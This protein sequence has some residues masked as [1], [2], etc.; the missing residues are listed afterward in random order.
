MRLSA[1]GIF[2]LA[3]ILVVAAAGLVSLFWTPLNP[4]GINLGA[5]LQ[6]PS[7]QNLFGTD[8]FGRD[9]FSRAMVGARTSLLISLMSVGFAVVLGTFVGIAAGYSRGFVDRI[10]MLGT[11]ALLAFPGVLLALGIII[12]FG[13]SIPGLV[14]ALGLSYAPSV[15]RVVRSTVLSLRQRE[16]IEAS[17]VI[18]NSEGYTMLAHVL[19][20]CIVPVIVL[21]TSMFGWVILLESA[22]SF[23]G[24]GIA[25]PAPTWGNMLSGGRAFLESAPW[26]GIAPGVCITLTLLGINLFGDALRDRYDPRMERA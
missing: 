3:L 17:R 22:L 7:M 21:G 16:F 1:Q 14:L 11:N 25:P 12:I 9:V 19:P 13:A 18:G 26:L 24:V 10:L 15:I 20:N 5:R 23:L 6:P 8:E 2:G 4:L